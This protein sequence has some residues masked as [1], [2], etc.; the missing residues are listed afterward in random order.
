MTSPVMICVSNEEKNHNN[1]IET[2][3]KSK[4]RA[5]RLVKRVVHDI[6]MI[7]MSQQGDL[8]TNNSSLL[9]FTLTNKYKNK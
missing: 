8:Q 4:K 9:S 3:E 2:Y 7:E 6:I 5:K 1:L